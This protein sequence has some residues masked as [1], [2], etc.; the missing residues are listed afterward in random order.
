MSDI[1]G[2][3]SD[4]PASRGD[5]TASDPNRAAYG[6]VHHG[7]TPTVPT[8]PG[9]PEHYDVVVIG[10]G[11]GGYS[12]ALRAAELGLS[13]ALVDRGAALGGTCL[14][15]GCIPS[16]AII[17]ATHAIGTIRRA[18]EMGIDATLNGI[19]FGRLRSYRLHVVDTMTKG[20][21]GLLAHRGVTV[22]RGE[23]SVSAGDAPAPSDPAGSAA[24]STAAGTDRRVRIEAVTGTQAVERFVRAGVP[25]PQGQAVELRAGSVVLALG[26]SPRPLPESPFGGALISS[27]QALSLDRFPSSVV[28]IGSGAVA[29]EFASLW[30]EAGCDV[31]M[32]IRHSRVLS[33]WDRRTATT[34]TREL[35]RQGVQVVAD[36]HVSRV[37]TGVNLGATVHYRLG[38]DETDVTAYG[39]FVLA[40][41]GRDPATNVPWL[42]PL[43][44]DR[45]GSGCITTDAWGRTTAIGVWA[46]GDATKGPALANRAFAQGIVVAE[47]IA[48]KNPDPV[49]DDSVTQVVFSSPE[50][51]SVGMTLD[52]ARSR[53][54]VHDPVETVY[55]MLSN[56]RMVMSGSTGALS[57]VSGLRDGCGDEPVV[58]GVHMVAPLAGDLIA[59]AQQLVGGMV[60]VHRASSLIHPHPT[61]SETLGEALLKADGRPL[62]TR[63]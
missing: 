12:A 9:T 43:A 29:V 56:A 26:S 57:V 50:A 3:A 22:F 10:A 20:L 17:T 4:G 6:Q 19:D 61:M 36:A 62:H 32:L 60:P 58:L 24:A 15:R 7:G 18:T 16:K 25:E 14:N 54:D 38:A 51:A 11:P 42:G 31:T 1:H 28:I 5:S 39:E 59:E 33:A 30:N 48:G 63:S 13:V 34:L 40:A 44:V 55:P 37:D 46:V 47:A 41:I 23:A 27:T 53:T 52:T 21:A 45:D 2:M 8:D 49:D 35:R